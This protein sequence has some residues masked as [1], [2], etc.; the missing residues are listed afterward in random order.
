[1]KLPPY[2]G[3]R[4]T[5]RR[6]EIDLKTPTR[7]GDTTLVILTNLPRKAANALKSWRFTVTT[8]RSRPYFRP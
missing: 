4:M 3:R 2:E 5:V 6:I 1:M 8:G 7:D